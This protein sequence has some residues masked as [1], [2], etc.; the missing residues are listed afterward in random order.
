MNPQLWKRRGPRR[1]PSAKWRQSLPAEKPEGSPEWMVSYADM[2]TI[3]LSFF[4]VMFSVASGDNSKDRHNK[5]QAAIDSLQY[6]FGPDWKPFTGWSFQPGGAPDKH[7]IPSHIMHPVS[8]PT[9]VTGPTRG[10]VQGRARVLVMG[11]GEHIAIGGPVDFAAESVEILPQQQDRLRVIA[12]EMAGKPQ[13]VD[14]VSV[15]S[16]RPLSPTAVYR[17]RWDLAYA[18][19][20]RTAELLA[21]MR[22]EP[23][24]FRIT[25][26]PAAA[27][28]GNKPFGSPTADR[29]VEVYLSEKLPA[30]DVR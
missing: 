1:P 15:A 5:Q 8:P 20:R 23:S 7:G 4:V 25:V 30:E 11:E 17:D 29:E 9:D 3:M 22:I 12:E 14:I 19:C 16:D 2:I 24:R 6:R 21:Q 18:R 13:Q 26:R 10:P 28:V 27:P